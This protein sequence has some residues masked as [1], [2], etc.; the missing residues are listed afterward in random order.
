MQYVIPKFYQEETPEEL[1]QRISNLNLVPTNETQNDIKEMTKNMDVH[2]LFVAP[3]SEKGIMYFIL[4]VHFI[5]LKSLV[6]PFL[7]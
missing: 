3:H 2:L 6:V 5:G 4:F 1:V 7:F